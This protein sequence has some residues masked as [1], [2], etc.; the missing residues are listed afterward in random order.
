MQHKRSSLSTFGV[1]WC[2]WQHPYLLVLKQGT[3]FR[4][5]IIMM[6]FG[7]LKFHFFH[8]FIFLP[9]PWITWTQCLNVLLSYKEVLGKCVRR[10]LGG[11]A[12]SFSGI[13]LSVAI[14]PSNSDVN[15][16]CKLYLLSNCL[17]LIFVVKE[18]R[19]RFLD[20]WRGVPFYWH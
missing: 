17:W 6:F 4:W 20:P 9:S 14:Q 5:L 18:L 12:S 8:S 7:S 15:V 16:Y 13:S 11:G 19:I 1:L 2:L 3:A 10:T